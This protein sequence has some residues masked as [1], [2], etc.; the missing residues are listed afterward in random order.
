VQTDFRES[1]RFRISKLKSTFWSLIMSKKFKL[2][3]IIT[4]IFLAII[5]RFYYLDSA[6][7]E[8]FGDIYEGLK[9]L[10][11]IRNGDLLWRF[12]L[13]DGPLFFYF[14]YPVSLFLGLSYLTLKVT[15]A[16]AGLA[17]IYFTYKLAKELLDDEFALISSFV[18]SVSSWFLIYTRMGNIQP[19]VPFCAMGALWMLAVFARTQKIRYLLASAFMASIGLYTYPAGFIIPGVLAFCLLLVKLHKP[20][21]KWIS[22]PIYGAALIILFLPMI[23]IIQADPALFGGGYIGSKLQTSAGVSALFESVLKTFTATHLR[24]DSGYRGNPVGAPHLDA[25]SGILMIL[26]LVFWIINIKNYKSVFILIPWVLLQVPSMVSLNSPGEVPSTGRTLGAAPIIYLMVATGLWWLLKSLRRFAGVSNITAN[27]TACIILLA[28]LGLN[29]NRYMYQYLPGLPYNNTAGTAFTQ[30]LVDSFSRETTVVLVKGSWIDDMPNPQALQLLSKNRDKFIFVPNSLSITCS[31]LDSL[32]S[33]SVII[34][35]FKVNL[36][37]D[38]LGECQNWLN[39]VTL[40]TT[41]GYPILRMSPL[42][43][44][45]KPPK[46]WTLPETKRQ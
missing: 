2:V 9:I 44:P 16:I 45:A 40:G 26:G 7:N 39:P 34:W 22:L 3:A 23:K 21:I 14:A 19:M 32:S 43:N 4:I 24:G 38:I 10:D 11:S 18:I 41:K 6:Q 27:T 1:W 33:P 17:T 36:P 8:V 30:N 42:M 29:A 35:D 20:S 12:T 13:G 31:Y 25:I 5:F 37:N 46:L 15:S 28:I